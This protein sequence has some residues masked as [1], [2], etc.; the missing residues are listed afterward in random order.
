MTCSQVLAI[1]AEDHAPTVA[2]PARIAYAI[3]ALEPFWGQKPVDYIRGETCRLYQKHRARSDATVR[4][5]L[6]TLRAALN[7]CAAEGYLI[8]VPVVSLP[9]KPEAQERFLTRQQAAILLWATRQLRIDGRRQ[10]QRF[11]LTGIYTGTRKKA[12]LALA[13]DMPSTHSGWI[14][15]QRGLIYRKGT[16]ERSTGKRRKP[17]RCPYRLLAHVRRW[18][19]LG[20]RHVCEDYRGHRV[21]DVRKGWDNLCDIA[22][23]IAEQEGVLMPERAFLTPHILK[24]TAITWAMQNGAKIEDAASFFST[25]IETIQRTYWHHS[26]LFQES[27]V[28]AIDNPVKALKQGLK[29]GR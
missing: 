17:A 14:D 12:A 4:R 20:A 25:S 22:Y 19:R 24:H 5:E 29:R 8:G 28:Q 21:A 11:I 16:Q 13:I 1:Y 9:A 7:F 3:D 2:D 27:A 10:M 6:G 23:E 26:P 15:T 18:K